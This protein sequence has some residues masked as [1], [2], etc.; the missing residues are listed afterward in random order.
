MRIIIKLF[1]RV[2]FTIIVRDLYFFTRGNSSP[3]KLLNRRVD[4]AGIILYCL[5]VVDMIIVVPRY[6]ISLL[7]L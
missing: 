1:E 7:W 3:I 6:T 2:V 4:C 5:C